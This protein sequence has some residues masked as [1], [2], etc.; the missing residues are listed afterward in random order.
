M[1]ATMIARRFL[2]LS[3]L[4]LCAF[5]VRAQAPANPSATA[6]Q[7]AGADAALLNEAKAFMA[8]YGA[9]LQ[10]GDRAAVIA[11]YDRN[12]V[13]EVRPASKVFTSHA[14]IAAR[15]QNEWDKPGFFEWRDLSYEVL[16]QDK[17]L[18]TGLFAWAATP[19]SKPDILSYVAI[20][21]RQDGALRIRLEA[22][23]W[24]DGVSV[25]MLAAAGV[26]F[27]LATLLVSWML[28]R[29]FRWRHA[30]KG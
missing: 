29:L 6:G 23:A 18:V 20:L 3:A 22:E 14:A 5:V 27:V 25:K 11:R 4:C 16:G 1:H 30:R 9:D 21:Q 28:R 12:G 8:D 7:P 19:S 17:V 15:Y 10:R 26:F 13:Y 2:L 24:G